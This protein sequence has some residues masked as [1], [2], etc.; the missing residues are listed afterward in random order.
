MVNRLLFHPLVTVAAICG[1]LASIALA[2]ATVMT[3]LSDLFGPHVAGKVN[4]WCLIV[5]AVCGAIAG[6]GRSP[7]HS[8]DSG[9]PAGNP[10]P[11]AAG[12]PS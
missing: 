3:P 1:V 8:I 4:D 6:L 7:I 11:P 9:A 10:S 12:T 5:A 2:L